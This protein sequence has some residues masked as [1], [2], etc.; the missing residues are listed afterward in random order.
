[1]QLYQSPYLIIEHDSAS[2]FQTNTWLASTSDLDE[3]TFRSEVLQQAIAARKNQPK[4]FLTD[5][6]DFLFPIHPDLQAW[7][8]NNIFTEMRASGVKKLALL[9]SKDLIAQ[10][11]IEQ[12]VDDDPVKGF[13]TQYFGEKDEAITWINSPN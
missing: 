4:A 1:M 5:A 7:V 13:V 11:G 3:A 10:L 6:C 9:I 2:N 12:L 8:N